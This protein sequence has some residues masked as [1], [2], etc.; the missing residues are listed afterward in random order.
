MEIKELGIF[1]QIPFPVFF[2]SEGTT[3]GGGVEA[4]VW[5]R[6]S[7]DSKTATASALTAL[8]CAVQ[9]PKTVAKTCPVNVT[10]YAASVLVF[11]KYFF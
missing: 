8:L 11:C 3:M 4:T 1:N 6:V 10:E 2:P 9:S 7:K 5:A